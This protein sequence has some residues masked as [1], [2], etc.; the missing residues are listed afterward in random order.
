MTRTGTDRNP[1]MAGDDEQP[2]IT[3]LVRLLEQGDGDCLRMV[4][5]TGAPVA[6]PPAV[7]EVL[8]QAVPILGY[9]NAVEIGSIGRS[10][11]T[12]QAAD[13]LVMPHAA[14]LALLDEGA[15]PS[16]EGTLG[17]EIALSDLLEY[18]AHRDAER[19]AALDELIRLTEEYGLYQIEK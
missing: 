16:R 11:T 4:D 7:L 15:I 14:L 12:H 6:L 17:V 3:A 10:L 1:I 8:R 13:L 5:A 18:K 2:A 19:R 9:R